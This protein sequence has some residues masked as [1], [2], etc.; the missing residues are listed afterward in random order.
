MNAMLSPRCRRSQVLFFFLIF[1]ICTAPVFAQPQAAAPE[2]AVYLNFDEG[3][4]LFAMDSSGHGNAGTLHNVSR[5][6][7]G[8]CSRALSFVNPDS[9]VSIPFRILNHPTREITVSTWFYIDNIT[10]AA[11]ISGYHNGGYRMGFDD[12]NDL[13][14]TVNLENTGDVSV[15]VQHENIAPGQWHHVTGTYDGNAMKIY[16]D[17]VLRNQANASGTIHYDADNYILLGADAGAADTPA[18]CPHYF[19]GGLDEVRIY[20]VALSYSQVMDDRFRCLEGVRSPPGVAFPE[21]VPESCEPVSGIVK[22]GTNA[23]AVH[24]LSFANKT[25]NGTW[26]VSLQPGSLL[27]VQAHD[28]Y[29][30]AYPDAWYLEIADAQGK[31]AR[32]ITFPNRINAPAEAVLPSGNA[33][34]IVRYFSGSEQFPAKVLLQLKSYQPV[35]PPQSNRNYLLENPI[36]V[37]YSASW[38]TLVA[39]LLVI[40]WLK[41][42]KKARITETREIK[43]LPDED[44]KKIIR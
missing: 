6:E 27:S 4:G 34:V 7:S 36:I 19:T 21:I 1:L 44:N 8:G 31:P 11:L 13:W 10:P 38:A 22:L 3:S 20:P 35:P 25:I 14:W 43:S 23:T 5:I 18:D 41:W 17:G 33:T 15:P 9:Y 32:T 2:P 37:I 42:R 30:N 12:G 39:I 40:I 24:V 29:M 16:L 28:F 26:Q